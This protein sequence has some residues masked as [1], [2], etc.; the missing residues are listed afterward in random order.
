[1]DYL[2]PAFWLMAFCAALIMGVAGFALTRVTLSAFA[3]ATDILATWHPFLRSLF[4][5]LVLLPSAALMVAI[6]IAM[7]WSYGLDGLGLVLVAS[8]R[9][10]FGH[11]LEFTAAGLL[12]GLIG[13]AAGWRR[14]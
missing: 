11:T 14:A 7:I 6:I 3:L 1:M 2:D 10:L 8:V 4:S 5:L 9:G 13:T 12:G